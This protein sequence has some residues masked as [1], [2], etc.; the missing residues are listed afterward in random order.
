ML[1]EWSRAKSANLIPYRRFYA[2]F[3]EHFPDIRLATELE[4]NL[5]IR[6]F[7][8]SGSFARTHALVRKL[9]DREHFSPAQRDEIV[10]I[11]LDNDQVYLI[12]QD[13]DVGAF[14]SDLIAGHEDEIDTDNL[15]MLRE[16]LSVGEESLAEK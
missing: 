13:P 1:D 2:F 14:L 4:A 11:A 16:K 7:A 8:Q 10:S 6:D 3:R 15:Q 9:R 5:L 12:P